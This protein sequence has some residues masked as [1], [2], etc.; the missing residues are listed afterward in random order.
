M[1]A[2]TPDEIRAGSP[3]VLGTAQ[4]EDDPSASLRPKKTCVE[5]IPRVFWMVPSFATSVSTSKAKFAATLV[6]VSTAS[7]QVA[8]PPQAPPKARNRAWGAGAGVS[9]TGVPG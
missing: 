3:P 1:Y 4:S 5:L 9:V 2:G 7:E 6:S 8:R